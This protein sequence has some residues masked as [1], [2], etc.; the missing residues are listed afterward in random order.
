MHKIKH[1]INYIQKNQV[2]SFHEQIATKNSSARVT[3]YTPLVK[4]NQPVSQQMQ[5]WNWLKCVNKTYA[6]T[7][8]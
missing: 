4:S 7:I 6:S 2:A 8:I 1:K 5:H 3:F